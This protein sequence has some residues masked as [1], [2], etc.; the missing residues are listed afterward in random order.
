MADE[1]SHLQSSPHHSIVRF[2]GE[3]D[4][5]TA[6]MLRA[7][8]TSA[9]ADPLHEF[10][11]GLSGVTFMDC[12]GLAPLLEAQANLGERLRLRDLPWAVSEVLHLTGLDDVF[13]IDGATLPV[14]AGATG[15][16]RTFTEGAPG[17]GVGVAHGDAV[18]ATLEVLEA[19]SAGPGAALDHRIVIDQAVGLLMASLGCD[20]R[21]ATHALSQL[22]WDQDAPVQDVAAAMVA[23][24]AQNSS[25]AAHVTEPVGTSLGR[26]R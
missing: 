26:T 19:Q 18:L 17:E 24:A 25:T 5:L 1:V 14:S 20:A 15:T 11:V 6:P 2:A 10:V 22:S 12:S 16:S 8:M 7:V 3:L 23:A 4:L 21:Q 9:D 13:L